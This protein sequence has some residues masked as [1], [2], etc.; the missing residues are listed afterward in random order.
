MTNSI[1]YFSDDFLFDLLI[2]L[3]C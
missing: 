2:D 3:S 1:V